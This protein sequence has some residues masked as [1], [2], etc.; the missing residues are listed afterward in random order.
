MHAYLHIYTVKQANYTQALAR[1]LQAFVAKCRDNTSSDI[2]AK[3]AVN[4]LSMSQV[5]AG[6]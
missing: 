4:P 2:D 3:L 1:A 6:A 5:R